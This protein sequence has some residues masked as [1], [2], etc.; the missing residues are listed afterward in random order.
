MKTMFWASQQASK[1]TYGSILG[2]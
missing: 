2:C 1:R